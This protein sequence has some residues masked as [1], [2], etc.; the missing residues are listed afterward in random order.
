MIE[1]KVAFR[2]RSGNFQVARLWAQPLPATRKKVRCEGLEMTTVATPVIC[3]SLRP[4]LLWI[5][6]WV[7]SVD[8]PRGP[9]IPRLATDCS[10][11]KHTKIVKNQRVRYL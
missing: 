2:R 4:P 8:T 6:L 10:K 7:T 3:H 5:T 9:E 1:N 11:F